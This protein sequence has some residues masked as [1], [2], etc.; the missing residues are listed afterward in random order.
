MWSLF[1]SKDEIASSQIRHLFSLIFEQN[2][3]SI[4][5]SFLNIDI[6]NLCF[7]DQSFTPA[8]YAFVGHDL[9][10]SMALWAW[11]LHLHLHHSHVN[12]LH[13]NTL[14]SALG[15]LLQF[16]VFGSRTS[17]VVTVNVS[18]NIHFPLSSQVHLLKRNRDFCPS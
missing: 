2:G 9:S 15:T 4:V 18:V 5:S 13:H 7:L 17:A 12:H 1:D 11:L 6:D 3:I 8:L 14:A 16:S 10:L